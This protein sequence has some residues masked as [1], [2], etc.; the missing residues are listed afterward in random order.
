[1]LSA[2]C[3]VY[4]LTLYQRKN[5]TNKLLPYTLSRCLY[6]QHFPTASP[7]SIPN[8]TMHS[9]HQFKIHN[10]NKKF[11]P[12]SLIKDLYLCA[13]VILFPFKWVIQELQQ[14]RVMHWMSE[15]QSNPS[16]PH[17]LYDTRAPI[18]YL[19]YTCHDNQ[20]HA[21][22]YCWCKISNHKFI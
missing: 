11:I 3:C 19:I 22:G 1:M 4:Q 17:T 9:K 10:I 13:S 6:H 7:C 20:R 2:V 15:P 16:T 8:D 12:F 5:F 21:M 14:H 18:Q